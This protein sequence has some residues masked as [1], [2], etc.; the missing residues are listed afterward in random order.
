MVGVDVV[1][2]RCL[3]RDAEVEFAGG[4]GHFVFEF[5]DGA[6]GVL[7]GFQTAYFVF[8]VGVDIRIFDFVSDV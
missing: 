3:A 5:E 2:E 8:F 1:L 4:I 7:T 6:F